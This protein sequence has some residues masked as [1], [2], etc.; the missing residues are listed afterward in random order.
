[1]AG[2]GAGPYVVGTKPEFTADR[3]VADN[4][5]R[6]LRFRTTGFLGD[7]DNVYPGESSTFAVVRTG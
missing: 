1:M 3:D 2:G 6:R 7:P 4:W 5:K